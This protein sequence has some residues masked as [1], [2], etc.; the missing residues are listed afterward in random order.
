MLRAFLVL[1]LALLAAG[2]A[3]R[4]EPVPWLN[5]DRATLS[6][7]KASTNPADPNTLTLEFSGGAAVTRTAAT[8]RILVTIPWPSSAYDTALAT[9]LQYFTDHGRAATFTV[10]PK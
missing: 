5:L 7:W 4:A 9:V 2:G 10:W 8:V 1:I 3:A 6:A